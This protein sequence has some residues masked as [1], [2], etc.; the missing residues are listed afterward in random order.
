MEYASGGELFEKICNAGHFNEGSF[1]FSPTH[2][3]GQLLSC[4]VCHRDL[5]LENTLLD[6]SLTLHFN[7][8]DFGYSKM[9]TFLLTLEIADVW[10][11]GV[12]LFVMLVGSYPF[13]DPN[14]PKDFRKTIQLEK[15]L[16]RG[17]LG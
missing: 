5:K 4:N 14:D 9:G 12:T 15:N 10:S 13:E 7:I 17:S 16:P 2:I 6:G 8:C 11:C 3:G 1:L